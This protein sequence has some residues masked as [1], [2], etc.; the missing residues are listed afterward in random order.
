MSNKIVISVVCYENNDEVIQFAKELSIQNISEKLLLIVTC[1]KCSHIEL[2]DK[3][4]RLCKV[5]YRIYDPSRN[6][7]YLYG[8]LYGLEKYSEENDYEWA[9]ISNTDVFFEQ[10]DF[11]ERFM[12]KK[13]PDNVWCV[14]PSIIRK[15][16]RSQSNPFLLSRPSRKKMF[17]K[18]IVY[19]NK[20]LFYIYYA[21]SNQKRKKKVRRHCD[22]DLCEIYASHGCSFF[23]RSDCIKALIGNHTS[24]FL[25][26][27]EEL[28]AGLVY[29]NY[30]IEYFFKE[31]ELIHDT[32]QV[33]GSI[34][35][36]KKQPWFKDSYNYLYKRFFK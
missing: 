14:A 28:V 9:V 1:N 31:I 23:A 35:I 16:D 5:D 7:G 10:N 22:D 24:I 32:N 29:E 34:S 15:N 19:S 12:Y 27:E 20:L 11:F 17:I 3:N 26:G 18:K 8:C 2:L 6:L 33:M 21:Y 4:L 13:F 25:Y 36:I 30:K